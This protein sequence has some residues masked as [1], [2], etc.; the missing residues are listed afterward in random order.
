[1]TPA[2]SCSHLRR[3]LSLPLRD[4]RQSRLAPLRRFRA[5]SVM[6]AILSDRRKLGKHA[7]NHESPRAVDG[8]AGLFSMYSPRSRCFLSARVDRVAALDIAVLAAG[9]IF[10]RAG[11]DLAAGAAKGVVIFAQARRRPAP[12]SRWEQAQS[13]Q[14]GK[15]QGDSEAL[16]FGKPHAKSHVDRGVAVTRIVG[17]VSRQPCHS[18]RCVSTRPRCAIAHRSSLRAPE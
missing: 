13:A 6:P 18:G 9:D 10:G 2:T 4:R 15:H 12:R 11:R 17:F 8:L 14:R 3:M 1:M 16:E 7:A 5:A